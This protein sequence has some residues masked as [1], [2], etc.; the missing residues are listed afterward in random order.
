MKNF[1]RKSEFRQDHT[2]I[3]KDK[4]RTHNTTLKTQA[5]VSRTKTRVSS[6]ASEGLAA[7]AP[8]VVSVVI[9][10]RQSIV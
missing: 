10:S 4:Y 8:L 6:G 7:T 3:M 9:H 1:D 2:N 5:G